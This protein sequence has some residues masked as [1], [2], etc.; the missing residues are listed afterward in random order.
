M[1]KVQ[2]VVLICFEGKNPLLSRKKSFQFCKK[3]RKNAPRIQD[4]LQSY[5]K[6][7]NGNLCAVVQNVI[8]DGQKFA[9]RF[10]TKVHDGKHNVT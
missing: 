2:F 6:Q 4:F 10:A 1:Q 7:R 3:A 8:Q 5:H 9:I